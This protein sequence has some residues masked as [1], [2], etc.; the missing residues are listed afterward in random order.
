MADR[1]TWRR[2][3]L[4]I[5][6]N[7]GDVDLVREVLD[8]RAHITWCPTAKA[9]R[10]VLAGDDNAGGGRSIPPGCQGWQRISLRI[11]NHPPRATP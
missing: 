2:R 9:A 11:V 5:E 10:E 4:I 3:V 7:E 8:E 1:G 6:D